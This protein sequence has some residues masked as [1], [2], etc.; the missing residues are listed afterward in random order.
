MKR[1][2]TTT[3]AA[4]ALLI[5]TAGAAQA[6]LIIE[7]TRTGTNVNG[8]DEITFRIAGYTGANAT[9]T[10]S[11]SDPNDGGTDTISGIQGTFAAVGAGATLSVPG[12]AATFRNGTTNADGTVRENP[13]KSY[14][15]FDSTAGTF[16]R[17][18]ATAVPTTVTGTWFTADSTLR[19]RAADITPAD[20]FEQ[21]LLAQV[22]VTPGADVSFDGVFN[23][24]VGTSQPL[25]FTSVPE[26]AG[27]ALVSLGVGA[28]LLRRRRSAH[29]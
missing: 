29:R 24:Y 28:A 23:S 27:L 18:P 12:T 5:G 16:T 15:N 3:A 14:A 6:A 22:Y 17:D 25:S 1:F 10:G 21:T 19:L 26:P 4:A 8:F 20:E 9:S 2:V 7:S 11:P 13:P